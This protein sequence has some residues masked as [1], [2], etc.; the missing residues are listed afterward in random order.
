LTDRHVT[1]GEADGTFH[2]RDEMI[3]GEFGSPDARSV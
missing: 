2:F 1:G 3:Q